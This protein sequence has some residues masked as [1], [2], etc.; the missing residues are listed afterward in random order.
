MYIE[1]PLTLDKL[2]KSNDFHLLDGSVISSYVETVE[3]VC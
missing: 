2:E 3:A 1:V